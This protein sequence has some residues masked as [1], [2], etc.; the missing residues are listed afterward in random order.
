MLK[1]E[2][3]GN[4]LILSNETT[5]HGSQLISTP[6]SRRH[7][8]MYYTESS[9]VGRVLEETQKTHDAMNIGV[10]GLGAGTL[11]AYARPKDQIEFWDVDPNAILI[12]NDFFRFVSDS[13]GRI[14]IA[15]DDG[16][17]GLE[18]SKSDYDLIVI[19]AF[20]GD[21]IPPHLLTREAMAVYFGRVEKRKGLVLI[22]ATN[23]YNTIFP[24]IGAT[25]A[26]LGW[27]AINVE[28][29]I[30]H[31]TDTRDWDGVITQY[32]LLCRPE[33]VQEITEWLPTEEDEGR[34]KR[35]VALFS[36]RMRADTIV[37]TDDR[38]AALDALNLSRYLTGK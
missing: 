32:V 23:R 6:E 38:H 8:T 1:T 16:R 11:A 12:A 25:A 15:Q 37:W 20:S 30:E 3:N 26:S 36:Y 2:E 34:V 17:K 19:D 29:Q 33:Q 31:T 27:S 18:S 24:V 28:T 21:A 10:V 9:G 5:T 14:H 13:P 22:H 7:P 35:T 4:G